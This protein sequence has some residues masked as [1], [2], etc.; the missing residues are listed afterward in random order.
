[1]GVQKA[2]ILWR[3]YQPPSENAL[4]KLRKWVCALVAK[5]LSVY[6]LCWGL[7]DGFLSLKF[8]TVQLVSWALPA[9]H[10]NE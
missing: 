5:L 10:V 6:L 7:S 4:S 8:D 3:G 1:V 9:A 2:G